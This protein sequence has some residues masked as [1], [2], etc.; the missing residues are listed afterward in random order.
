M[1]DTTYQIDLHQT[2]VLYFAHSNAFHRQIQLT[3]DID[4]KNQE[5]LVYKEYKEVYGF[6]LNRYSTPRRHLQNELSVAF[7]KVYGLFSGN[8]VHY[9]FIARK[10]SL[11]YCS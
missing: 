8:R 5:T 2:C 7:C 6:A 4:L 9:S 11:L 3:R 10:S 1:N